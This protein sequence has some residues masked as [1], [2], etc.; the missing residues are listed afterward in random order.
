MKLAKNLTTLLLASLP[1]QA[2]A[3]GGPSDRDTTPSI[4]AESTPGAAESSG[5]ADVTVET[6][7]VESVRPVALESEPAPT[8][9]E[10]ATQLD[11]VVVTATKRARASRELPVSISALHGEDLEK[12]GARDLKD[13]I[14][15]VP[16]VTL[17]D[18]NQGDAGNRK[19]TV[20]GVGPSTNGGIAGNQPVGQFIGDIPMTDPYS[21]F[22]TPDLDPFDLKSVEILKGPQGTTFGASALNGAIRYVPN[23]PELG[24]WSGRGFVDYLSY[25]EG[26][27]GFSY[28]GAMNAPLGDTVAVRVVGVIQDAPGAVD[29]LASG[30]AD[31]DSREKWTG[32]GMIRWQPSENWTVTG[33]YLKQE[34]KTNDAVIPDHPDGRLE[35]NAHP[36]PQ[37]VE[38]GF[39]LASLD[40]R[41]E[42]DELGTLVLQSSRQDKSA[43]LDADFLSNVALGISAIRVYGD[44]QIEGTTHEMRLVSP[45]GG[46][47]NWIVGAFM[48]DYSADAIADA[49]VTN[50]DGLGLPQNL[51]ENLYGP[52]GLSIVYGV[53]APQAT[54]RSLYGE[55]ERNLG[56]QWRVTLG[57]RYYRTQ[58]NGEQKSSGLLS[59]LYL[60]SGSRETAINQ[61]DSGF[62]PKLAVTYKPSEHWTMYAAVAR[63]F[64]FGGV[65]GPALLTLPYDNPLTGVPVEPDYGSSTIW[66]RELGVRTDWFDRTLRLDLTLFDLDWTDA[67]FGQA[68]GGSLANNLYTDNVGQVRSQGVETSLTWLTPVPGVSFNLNGAYVRARTASDFEDGSGDIV[69]SGTQMPASPTV[70]TS[71]ALS[72]TGYFDGWVPAAS[73]LHTYMG[74]AWAN[75]R[76]TGRIYDFQALGLT[77]SVGRPDWVGAPS[78]SLGISN[79]LDERGLVGIGGAVD[80]TALDIGNP[81]TWMYN[82]PRSI[83]LRLTAEF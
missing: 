44:Y 5:P 21:N 14:S 10:P 77:M 15:Q 32:R 72:W 25:S 75:I 65:N 80:G 39:S 9:Y 76:H 53:V 6:I 29:N 68:S 55:L 57:G 66:S 35:S 27:A 50:T 16:G 81:P 33:S 49:Y 13:F 51:P 78:L 46:D 31:A 42:F 4:E 23:D 48:L 8:G 64:Q 79:L 71:A 83:S 12:I 1:Y 20:R 74:P 37:L 18:G 56:E 70:Q 58:I 60:A 40:V 17:Q 26:D 34:A 19:I 52:R 69:R 7:P 61:E 67:Q 63:G 43:I 59:T 22:V 62:S 54:E 3:Q 82:R 24:I 38:V 30:E 2:V 47:W 28:G 41:Y 36:T 45:D 73:L 11:D